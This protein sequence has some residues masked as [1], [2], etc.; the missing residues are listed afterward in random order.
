MTFSEPVV[1]VGVGQMGG[2]FARGFL[3]AGHPVYPVTSDMTMAD[4]ARQV[5]EPQFVLVA[6]PENVLA[7]TLARV[8][9]P[10]R[11]QLGLLQNELL[12]CVWEKAGIQ[13]PTAMA[14]WFEKKKGTDV[15]VFQAT[16]VY[17]P[18]AAIVQ[19]GLKAVDIPC[20]VMTD[21]KALLVALIQKT[22]YVLTINI[23]GLV[24]GG[25][26][27]GLWANHRE[28]AVNVASDIMDLLDTVT[29]YACDR[30]KM[31]AF[32]GDILEKVP[33][34]QCRGRVAADRLARVMAHARKNDLQ[35]STLKWI[36]Q[37]EIRE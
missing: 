26:T 19:A 15:H 31:L 12:P 2:V 10:W 32:L 4:A 21:E 3:N 37:R 22:L 33:N 35:L 16:A 25:T 23:A 14:V 11:G 18:N 7:E 20:D 34:H 13:N 17:G 1:V 5:P 6:V 36:A 28:L 9:G 8:P 27:G 24:S 29:P 30:E